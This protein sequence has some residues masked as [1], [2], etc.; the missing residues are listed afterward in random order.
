MKQ[1][2]IEKRKTVREVSEGRA[3]QLCGTC[4]VAFAVE[5]GTCR[6]CL[7]GLQSYPVETV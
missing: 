7:E 2:V 6:E 1:L 4:R 3:A 5:W